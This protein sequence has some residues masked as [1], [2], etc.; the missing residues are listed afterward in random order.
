MKDT[1]RWD[2]AS[3]YE[4]KAA[5][6]ASLEECRKLIGSFAGHKGRIGESKEELL[7]AL[8][9]L[10]TMLEKLEKTCVY[11]MLSFEAD[12]LDPEAREMAAKADALQ[13]S[14]A[15]AMSW[16]DPELM[17]IDEARLASWLEDPAFDAYRVFIKKS[18]HMKEHVLSDKEERLLSLQ[19]RVASLGQEAFQ[20]L[21]DVDLVFGEVDGK[22]LTHSSYGLFMRSGDRAV[23]KEA[24]DKLYSA[25][26]AHQH[27]FSRLLAG[28]VD[29]AVF[30][31]QARGYKSSLEAALDPDQVPVA[32]YHN[33]VDSVHE[34]FPVLRRYY[35][36]RKK[37]LGLDRLA[38][39]DVYT[40]ML[41]SVSTD[42]SYD[43]ALGLISRAIAP[44]GDEYRD[45]LVKGLGEDR[46]VDRYPRKGKRS[47]AFSSG[48]YGTKPFILTNYEPGMIGSV[49][50]LIHEG[51]HSMHSLLSAKANPYLSHE[52]TIFEAETASTFNE[53][54]LFRKLQEEA[55]D[56][57]LKAGL[58]AQRLDDM[59]ATFFRQTMF[60]EFELRIHEE[61]VTGALTL[62][63]MKN[64]YQGLL[65]AYFGPE[66][67][68][69]AQSCLECLRIPHFHNAF[70]VYKYATG[71]SA[72]IAL[73]DR[74]L[75]GGDAE[76]KAYLGFLSSGG[77]SYPVESLRKAGVDMASP[78]PVKSTVRRFEVMMDELE[79]LIAE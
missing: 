52:Y 66:V 42:I 8:E 11:A 28:S 9:D 16:W 64:T 24:Y 14:A 10:R 19:T 74:V 25:Y 79:A 49:F 55:T 1:D 59:V 67:E 68:F 43:E 47:G 21:N 75:D 20:D 54:L 12:G 26:E 70:Y 41:P 40:P 61:A 57:D 5:W 6:E 2:L 46:W 53:E 23:R 69:S 22:A 27:V 36:L 62:D 31:A 17:S 18:L 15:E 51:G 73:V 65:E 50:T 77:S 33:L 78:A 48:A 44:L 34:G 13:N 39:W 3:V 4:D 32:V 35:S 45:T 76:R 30:E 71:L 58:L 29:Q 7:A 38:H 72:A 56:K 37:L 60:A 63:Y